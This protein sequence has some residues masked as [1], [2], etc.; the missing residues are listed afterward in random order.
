MAARR[1]GWSSAPSPSRPDAPC[2]AREPGFHT[3]TG[4]ESCSTAAE[5]PARRQP[6]SRERVMPKPFHTCT[7]VKSCSTAAEAPARRQPQSR[8]RVMP[9]SFHTC[10]GVES[11][12]TA[13]Q[14]RARRQPPVENGPR[15]SHSTPVHVWNPG[16][17]LLRHERAGNPESRTDHAGI[18]PHLYRCGILLTR[19]RRSS[20]VL[21]ADPGALG[22]CPGAS[23]TLTPQFWG[24]FTQFHRARDLANTRLAPPPER[25][26]YWTR[27][28]VAWLPAH[29]DGRRGVQ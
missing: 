10:T 21:G 4:V 12:S 28:S 26:V 5:A 8:E 20:D 22:A 6:Q 27:W 13:A 14:A 25:V 23:E 19:R 15:P 9:K 3:C 7:G 29:E 11:C 24:H 17:L 18:I 1:S 16:P 2:H